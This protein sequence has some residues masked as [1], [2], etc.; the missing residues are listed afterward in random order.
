MRRLECVSCMIQPNDP[1]MIQLFTYRI[2][3]KLL[4]DSDESLCFSRP[5]PFSDFYVVSVMSIYRDLAKG[6]VTIPLEC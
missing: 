6:A 4:L 5:M 1:L 2:F 3:R